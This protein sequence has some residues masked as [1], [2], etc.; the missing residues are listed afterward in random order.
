MNKEKRVQYGMI[1]QRVEDGRIEQR[2]QIGQ[3]EVEPQSQTDALHWKPE[4]EWY[5]EDSS[6]K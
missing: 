4:E 6:K 1:D 2:F 3:D 5:D